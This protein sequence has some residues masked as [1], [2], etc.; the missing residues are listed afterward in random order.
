MLIF[1]I[2]VKTPLW[3]WSVLGYL[4]FKGI[5]AFQPC[6][7]G[8]YKIFLFPALFL[9]ISL[10]GL[11]ATSELLSF[12]VIVRLGALCIGSAIGFVLF[13]S[14]AIEA[15]KKKSL[16]KI[17]GTKST[18]LLILAIFAI[19]YYFGY[20]SAR[21]PFL[22]NTM[23]FMSLQ[24]IITGVTSGIAIGRSLCYLYKYK[25]AIHTDLR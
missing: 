15:D 1:T 9:L 12:A 16:I 4:L 17:P 20:K 18:L 13:N 5:R 25:T 11:L 24:L 21:D 6:T 10:K 23:Y 22:V 7:V 8:I 2:I 3:V 14:I 19:K